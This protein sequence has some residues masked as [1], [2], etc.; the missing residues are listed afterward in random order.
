MSNL[1][2]VVVAGGG[3]AGATASF[4]LR[5]RG[6]EGLPRSRPTPRR[7]FHAF[8]LADPEIALTDAA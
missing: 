8:W 1:D 7:W 4:A 5:G 3:L 6:F 2:A